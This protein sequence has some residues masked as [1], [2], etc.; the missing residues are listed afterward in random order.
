[1]VWFSLFPVSEA[2]FAPLLLA[3]FYFVVRARTQ[4]VARRTR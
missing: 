1:M 2:L 3:F 4:H